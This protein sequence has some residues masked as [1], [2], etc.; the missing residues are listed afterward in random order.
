MQKEA[1]T[2]DIFR[3]LQAAAVAGNDV[4]KPAAFI[5]FGNGGHNPDGTI[6]PFDSTRESMFNR[7]VVVPLDS[8]T[9]PDLYMA[10]AKGTT[11][12]D[13]LPLVS[14]AALYDEDMRIMCMAVFP[15]KT[16]GPGETYTATL[17][18]RF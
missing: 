12:G 15:P 14:E 7:L 18:M 6:K 17:Q 11:T 16:T 9:Q 10:R 1:V 13:A 4:L 3:R 2:L 5:G 8:L